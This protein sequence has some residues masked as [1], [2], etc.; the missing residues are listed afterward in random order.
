LVAGAA[1]AAAH[2]QDWNHGETFM[3]AVGATLSIGLAKEACD[4]Y[5]RNS[6]S[7]KN[8]VWNVFGGLAGHFVAET[9]IV[10]CK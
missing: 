2:T 3:I 10:Q 9:L 6:W 8:T 4:G 7:W 5:L 1:T